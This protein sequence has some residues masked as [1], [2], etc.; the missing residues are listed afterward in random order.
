MRNQITTTRLLASL[1]VPLLFAC[2]AEN[3]GGGGG[4]VQVPQCD[5]VGQVLSTDSSG[6]LI[7]KPLPAGALVLPPCRK[8]ADALTSD[9]KAILPLECT[10]R[11]N[12][13]AASTKA[14]ENLESSEKLINDY[15]TRLGKINTGPAA[16][17]V[18]CGQSPQQVTNG[19]ALS[20]GGADG[21]PAATSICSKVAA[22]GA[23]ARMCSVY[24]MYYSVA[25]GVI[26]N[27]ADVPKSWVYMASWSQEWV[28][29]AQSQGGSG[30]S[31][32]CGGFT[33]PTAD[34]KW[35]G[36]AVEW[37]VSGTGKKALLF[38][39]GPGSVLIPTATNA[40]TVATNSFAVPCSSKLPIACCK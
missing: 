6:Q 3:S 26:N 12:E 23:N 11:N 2:G 29:P 19:A 18:Y 33:Y 36:T 28:D 10:P 7:C 27:G 24:D 25:S 31:D 14:L 1:V 35:Y 21:I 20:D 13:S 16:R 17:A 9:P 38:H 15:T 4:F 37:K 39:S 5:T 40:N 32:N 30:Q 8:Y 22:C 34:R